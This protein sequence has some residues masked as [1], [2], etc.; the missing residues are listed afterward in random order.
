MDNMNFCRSRKRTYSGK[1]TPQKPC[2][3]ATSEILSPSARAFDDVTLDC[4]AARDMFSFKSSVALTPAPLTRSVSTHELRL[5]DIVN[6]YIDMDDPFSESP[7]TS[8]S[9]HSTPDISIES[10]V[11]LEEDQSPVSGGSEPDEFD[12]DEFQ[13]ESVLKRAD[14]MGKSISLLSKT[15]KDTSS[16]IRNMRTKNLQKRSNSSLLV[17]LLLQKSSKELTKLFRICGK[18]GLSSMNRLSRRKMVVVDIDELQTIGTMTD[19]IQTA[20]LYL[21]TNGADPDYTDSDGM[22]PLLLACMYRGGARVVRQL[23]GSGASASRC[24]DDWS[25]VD[26]AFRL[27]HGETCRELLKREALPTLASVKDGQPTFMDFARTHQ[28]TVKNA[29]NFEKLAEKSLVTSLWDGVEAENIEWIDGALR[30]GISPSVVDKYCRTPLYVAVYNKV[31]SEIVR[32][33]LLAAR[34]RTQSI[35]RKH[36]CFV[37]R[38]CATAAKLWTPSRRFSASA[39]IHRPVSARVRPASRWWNSRAK[40]GPTQK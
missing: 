34:T 36:R 28:E 39:Q 17:E 13:A 12:F 1:K 21:L 33:Y 5:D 23:L 19:K 7:T 15:K 8:Q 3:T 35:D 2:P 18:S 6:D 32:C 14:S 37:S 26:I 29:D 31:P 38:S 27:G 40:M 11:S 20:A 10:T 16:E 4:R 9:S 25:L 24:F 30:H 22:F